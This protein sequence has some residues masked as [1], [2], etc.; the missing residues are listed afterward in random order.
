MT[1]AAQ[2][3]GGLHIEDMATVDAAGS[4]YIADLKDELIM[5]C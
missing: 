5:R 4:T 1:A 2:R 3:G